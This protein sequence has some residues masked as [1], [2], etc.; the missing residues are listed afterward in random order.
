MAAKQCCDGLL[1][2]IQHLIGNHSTETGEEKI[3]Q[4]VALHADIA[5][6]SC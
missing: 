6:G 3:D 1:F 2:Y 5:R 4:I